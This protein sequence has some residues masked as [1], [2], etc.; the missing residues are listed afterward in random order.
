MEIKYS[1]GQLKT[2]DINKIS[3]QELLNESWNRSAGSDC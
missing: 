1:D 2:L 3:V